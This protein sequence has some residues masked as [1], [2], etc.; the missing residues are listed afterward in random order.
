MNCPRLIDAFGFLHFP[1]DA[2]DD[3]QNFDKD[4]KISQKLIEIKSVIS[5]AGKDE[6]VVKENSGKDDVSKK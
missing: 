5:E 3:K 4:D 1:K 2:S 6:E